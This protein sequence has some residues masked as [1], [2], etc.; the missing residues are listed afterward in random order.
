MTIDTFTTTA[1]ADEFN[2]LLVGGRV[3]D[4]VQLDHDTFGME[5]YTNRERRYLLLCAESTTPRAL[6][7]PEKLRRG[8]MSPSTMGLLI[9]NRLEGMKLIA[10]RQPPWERVLIF[11]FLDET[12]EVQLILEMIERRAN[13]LLVENDIIA[14]CV[15]RVGADEN[16]YRVS[17]PKHPYVPPPPME[18]KTHPAELNPKVL[19]SLLMREPDQ[20]AWSVLVKNV[21]GFSPFLAKEAIFRAYGRI[22]MRASEVNPYGL[23]AAL[24]SFLRSLLRN[25]WQPGVAV[26]EGGQV[27]GV[28]AY[29]LTHLGEWEPMPTISE[30]L[31]SY[32]G[33]LEGGAVYEAA[34][35]PIRLQIQNAQKKLERK[36]GSLKKSLVERADVEHLR[37]A[38]ELLLAY[39][40][41]IQKGQTLFEAEYEVDAPPLKIKL[42]PELSAL[43]NA[44]AYFEK[45]EKAKRGRQQVP[46]YIAQVESELEFLD[47]LATDLDLAENWQDIG[48]VQETLMKKG[49]WQGKKVQHPKGGQSGPLRYVTPDGFVIWIGRNARQNED[50]TFKKG[51]DMDI[52][53]H[54][55]GVPGSHVVIKTNG[56]KVPPAIMEQAARFAAYYSKLRTEEK[57]DV[58]TAER[59]HVRKLKGGHPGQVLVREE[60]GNLRVKP[61]AV[62]EKPEKGEF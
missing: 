30:A 47:Q 59:R 60:L 57:V 7:T 10:V 6:I 53:M 2:E 11:D 42:D 14:D 5:I 18:G 35:E 25:E 1:I 23:D 45:Y 20:K 3:Q 19:N 31:S 58:I 50:V 41:N 17:L 37:M 49:Y 51:E 46:E 4:T 33:R 52:W 28:A 40:Y 24:G 12:G 38:G 54:A 34:R 9:R 22:D 29:P 55:R 13:L 15:R 36:L 48:E 44:K 26:G 8:V 27:L 61:M 32:Y 39:Q 43:D 21:Y 56:R 62:P 16:R